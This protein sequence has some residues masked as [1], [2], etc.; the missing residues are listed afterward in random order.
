MALVV[1][2]PAAN[3]GD[4]KETG[5]IPP[6]GRS[7]AG[8]HGSP[9]QRSC[10]ENLMHRGARRAVVHRIAKSRTQLKLLMTH[11]RG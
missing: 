8:E 7:P 2:N 11:T 3:A 9:L 10:L 4:M 6:V 5:W 1:K